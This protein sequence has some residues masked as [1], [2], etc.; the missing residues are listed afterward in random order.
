MKTIEETIKKLTKELV[1]CAICDKIECKIK[2]ETCDQYKEIYNTLTKVANLQE[3]KQR[4]LTLKAFDEWLLKNPRITED[5]INRRVL[6]E[7]RI[8]LMSKENSLIP[9]LKE[10]P[11]GT[12]LYSPIYGEVK[13]ERVDEKNGYIEVME[14]Y[15]LKRFRHDGT[16][17]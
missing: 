17:L 12:V 6:A 1:P 11:K 3:E 13:F 16:Y 14:E 5:V 4:E 7:L 15:G 2:I 10:V 8:I 9:I